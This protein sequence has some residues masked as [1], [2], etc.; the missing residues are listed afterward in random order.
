M[1][2]FMVVSELTQAIK[3]KYDVIADTDGILAVLPFG[4]IKSES[5]RNPVACYKVLD[6]AS[7]KALE[8]F[9][10]NIFGHDMNPVIRHAAT[11]SQAKKLREFFSK[12]A[13]IKAFLK[14]FDRKDEKVFMGA[15]KTSELE[16][17]DRLVRKDTVDRS[18]LIVVAGQ[19]MA[20]GEAG[21]D[22]IIYKE[23]AVLGV[24]GFLR[25]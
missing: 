17:A 18:I 21:E 12:N 13:V 7:K 2:G 16:P 5:R 4:E 11:S 19:F 20:F 6:L 8:V 3:Y 9:H 23:G 15:L 14:G 22:N 24:E 1:V 25:S 10:Y